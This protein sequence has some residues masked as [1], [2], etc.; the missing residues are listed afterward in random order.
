MQKII[1]IKLLCAF[2]EI[3]GLNNPYEITEESVTN[4]MDPKDP[5][6]HLS[7]KISSIYVFYYIIDHIKHIKLCFE[8]F[9]HWN[10]HAGRVSSQRQLR[11][12]IWWFAEFCNSHCVSHFAALFIGMGTKISIVENFLSYFF[13]CYETILSDVLDQLNRFI[14]RFIM[15][16]SHSSW[17]E[18]KNKHNK[19][20]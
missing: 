19:Q 7:C 4:S 14:K 1:K 9:R 2:K 15:L 11:S 8:V 3:S 20:N 16:L 17:E 6:I 18:V 5:R 12:R 13:C 10:R